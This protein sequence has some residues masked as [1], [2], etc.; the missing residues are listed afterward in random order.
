MRR[1]LHACPPALCSLWDVFASFS[2]KETAAIEVTWKQRG[3]RDCSFQKEE[4]T[5]HFGSLHLPP[6]CDF[7]STVS[8]VI[9]FIT[10]NTKVPWALGLE[11][12]RRALKIRLLSVSKVWEKENGACGFC[13][14]HFIIIQR[15]CTECLWV[16][17]LG[18]SIGLAYSQRLHGVCCLTVM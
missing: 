5:F 18:S 14:Y 4:S 11:K 9:I 1:D 8:T 6:T 15:T 12:D 16:K 3:K 7:P 13:H 17:D 2:F 10:V